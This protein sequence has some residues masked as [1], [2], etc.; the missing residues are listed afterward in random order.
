MT[1]KLEL[2]TPSFNLRSNVDRNGLVRGV[3]VITANVEAK[4][5][6][7]YTDAKTLSTTLSVASAFKEGVK[8][9]MDHSH[10]IDRI[11]GSISN[12]RIEGQQ[13]RGDLQ[14]LTSHPA[15]P[16]IA[17][18]IQ[19]QPSTIGLS[20]SFSMTT[21]EINKKRFIRV[22]DLFSCDL[23]E[24]P[25]CNPSGLLSTRTTPP[26]QTFGAAVAQL[27]M[28]RGLGMGSAVELAVR[29][30]PELHKNYLER[31]GGPL[32]AGPVKSLSPSAFPHLVAATMQ[33]LNKSK[34]DALTYCVRTYPKHYTAW[35]QSGD[36]STLLPKTV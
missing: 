13:L 25:A 20:I 33:G 26:P 15:Y 4:G 3:S 23:V 2:S 32:D 22:D 18:L 9:K 7:M 6:G 35:L 17:E 28:E 19:R 8:V 12:F 10:G 29:A 11:V 27:A 34:V 5:H 31:G 30:F 14:L 21:E 24:N 36:T 1:T 16:T